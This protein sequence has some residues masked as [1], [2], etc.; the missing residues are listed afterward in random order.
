MINRLENGWNVVERSS[1][2]W[3]RVQTTWPRLY[4]ESSAARN[5]GGGWE[6]RKSST[7]SAPLTSLPKASFS[8]VRTETKHFQLEIMANGNLLDSLTNVSQ[9]FVEE[10]KRRLNYSPEKIICN[11]SGMILKGREL[12]V[13]NGRL[14]LIS[15]GTLLVEKMRYLVDVSCMQFSRI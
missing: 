8:K 10:R 15:M 7:P 13:I 11:Y 12:V 5:P 2:Q 3:Q 14:L 4:T 9:V 1:H 6:V